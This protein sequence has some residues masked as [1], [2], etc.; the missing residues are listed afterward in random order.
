MQETTLEL[1]HTE[2]HDISTA[3]QN[4]IGADFT[5][6]AGTTDSY[7][8]TT[9]ASPHTTNNSH[10]IKNN[11]GVSTIMP[12]TTES[13]DGDSTNTSHGIKDKSGAEES[14]NSK[15]SYII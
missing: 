6:M 9:D 3:D 11:N 15:Y 14:T 1:H 10:G 2:P 7:D 13:Y 4:E 12:G 8:G 5:I